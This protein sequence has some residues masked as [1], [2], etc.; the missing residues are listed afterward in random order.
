MGGGSWPHSPC[1]SFLFFGIL[2]C[3][4]SGECQEGPAFLQISDLRAN[5]SLPLGFPKAQLTQEAFLILLWLHPR[6]SVV[7]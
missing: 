2:A 7:A 1:L 6:T 5:K 4:S 3:S